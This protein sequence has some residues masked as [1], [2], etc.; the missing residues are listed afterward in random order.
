[1]TSNENRPLAIA[2]ASIAVA[3]AVG[4]A[5]LFSA[6]SGDLLRPYLAVE[7]IVSIPYLR[8]ALTSAADILVAVALVSLA[9]RRSPV[10]ILGVAGLDAPILRPLLWGALVFAPAILFALFYA[11]QARFESSIWW[12]GIGGPFF[13]ELL[14]RGI[15]IGV[16]MRFC[17]WSLW[18]AC[19]MP[20]LFFGSVHTWQ[21]EDLA[22][23]AGVVAITGVGGLLLGWVFVR[24]GFNLW[25]AF[26][27]HA[28]LNCL[29]M[30][31]DLGDNAIGGWVGNGLRLSVIAL[32][33][34]ATFWLTPA[35]NRSPI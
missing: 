29:W 2:P 14:Y 3:L 20:A 27:A 30:V 4:G 32:A 12:L 1:M 5:L 26:I 31:F 9:A 19:L 13:E 24:W 10:A 7:P 25:P 35:R 11:P 18:P 8:A 28:G 22:S 16:L 21:G 15:A 23:V 6:L 17:G 33:I 34:A